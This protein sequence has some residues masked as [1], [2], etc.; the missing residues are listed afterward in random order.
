MTMYRTILEPILFYGSA[1]WAPCVSNTRYLRN[2]LRSVQ[3]RALLKLTSYCITTSH[4]K[5]L[6]VAGVDP[7]DITA[8]EFANSQCACLTATD[9]DERPVG[10]QFGHLSRD[11]HRQFQ[12]IC[13]VI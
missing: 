6:L 7:I 8:H 3:C 10:L 5:T 1:V 2:K 4:K 9:V 12:L 11:N 13:N